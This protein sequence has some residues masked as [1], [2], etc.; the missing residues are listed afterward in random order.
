[1]HYV[2]VIIYMY[3][4]HVSKDNKTVE[5]HL[6]SN[7]NYNAITFLFSQF[8]YFLSCIYQQQKIN[9]LKIGLM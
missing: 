7:P 1:M 2:C 8:S 6:N 9:S 5:N 3:K 4:M